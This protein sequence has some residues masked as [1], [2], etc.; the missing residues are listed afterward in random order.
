MHEST[1]L[2]LFLKIKNSLAFFYGTISTANVKI[3]G[4]MQ[5]ILINVLCIHIPE[6]S[7]ESW[8]KESP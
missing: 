8:R 1:Y 3:V 5:L 6:G 2:L 4:Q 7:E